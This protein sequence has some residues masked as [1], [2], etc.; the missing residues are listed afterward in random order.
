MT[1]STPAKGHYSHW[2]NSRVQFGASGNPL[3][4]I[5]AAARFESRWDTDYPDRS[6][7]FLS[8]PL[9]KYHGQAFK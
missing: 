1:G 6:S 9:G 8:V 7:W 2:N 3:T 5:F 4:C